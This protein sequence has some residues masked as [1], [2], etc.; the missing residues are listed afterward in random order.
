MAAGGDT[1]PQW[2]TVRV[3]EP[4]LQ[5]P[6]CDQDD[7][8]FSSRGPMRFEEA[9]AFRARPGNTPVWRPAWP[10]ASRHCGN[11]PM[12]QD[13]IGIVSNEHCY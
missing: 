3:T 11:V 13:G 12:Y 7:L 8:L 10:G 5:A 2:H 1:V 6:R 9:R 4:G